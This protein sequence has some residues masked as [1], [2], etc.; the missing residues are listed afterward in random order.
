MDGN[1]LRVIS[2]LTG[3]RR[4]INEETTKADIR[5][6]LREVYPAGACGDFTQALMELGATVCLPNGAPDCARCPLAENC[7]SRDGGWKSL[8]VK[9]PKK[10]RR[11][12]EWTV[13]LLRCGDTVALRKR[14]GSGLL[15]GLWEFP[16]LPGFLTPE[17]A[18]AAASGWGV[19]PRE[20]V[21]ETQRT[22][23][24]T[25]VEWEMLCYCFACAEMPEVFF[26]TEAVK[27]DS[28]IALP[29]AFRK[30]WE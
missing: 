25:H 1:V 11:R 28:E 27:L 2:R 19:S 24:F 6:A 5:D 13:F 16:N 29:T 17:E 22:H 18:A 20:L 8:P 3:D 9:S 26:W 15:A 30:L 14:P 23:I 10:P 7:E 12:E 21:Y 4:P